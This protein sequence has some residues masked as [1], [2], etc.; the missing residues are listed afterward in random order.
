MEQLGREPALQADEW[1]RYRR[2]LGG[3]IRALAPLLALLSAG[4]DDKLSLVAMA[5]LGG[6]MR[7]MS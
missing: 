2:R 7:A 4:S 3:E 1:P 6:G 5:L